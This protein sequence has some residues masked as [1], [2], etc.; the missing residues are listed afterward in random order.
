[1]TGTLLFAMGWGTKLATSIGC[2]CLSSNDR[3]SPLLFFEHLMLPSEVGA[4]LIDLDFY[5]P[6]SV[7]LCCFMFLLTVPLKIVM[8][9]LFFQDFAT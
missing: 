3:L 8:G 1:M 4:F 5:D 9:K 7:L 2:F 6:L